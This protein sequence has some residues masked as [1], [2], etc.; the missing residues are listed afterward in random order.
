VTGTSINS[1]KPAALLLTI[2]A[3][4]LVFAFS[5]VF[6]VMALRQ[7]LG[8]AYLL[9]VPGFVTVKLLRLDKF[10]LGEKALFSVGLSIAVLILVGL[11]G[12]EIGPLIGVTDP[13]ATETMLIPI[14]IYVVVG[15]TL[16]Y[17]KSPKTAQSSVGN[18]FSLKS[19]LF[20]TLP[21]LSTIGG[22]WANITNSNLL[23]LILIP[24]IALVFALGILSERIVPLKYLGAIAICG[25]I[26][27]L[28]HSS[29]ISQYIYGT[30]I[31][32][33]YYVL[34]L[35]Q[36]R[37]YWDS[38]FHFSDPMFGRYSN[39]LSITILPTLFSNLLS[40]DGTWVFKIIFPLIF[41][42]VPLGLFKIWSR[43]FGKKA[44]LISA[45][46]LISQS[47]FYTEMLGLGRQMIAEL[48]FVLLLFVFFSGKLSSNNRRICFMIF[49]FGL[50]VAHYGMALIFFFFILGTWLFMSFSKKGTK[51]IALSFVLLFAVIMFSWY[52]YTSSSA[53]FISIQSYGEYVYARLGDFF[54]PSSRG[55]EVNRGLGFE[56]AE[57]FWQLPSRMFAYATQAL[58]AVGLLSLLFSRKT[59]EI[60]WEYFSISSMSMALLLMAILLPGLALTLN[61]TRFYHIALLSLS[62]FFVLGCEFLANNIGKMLRLQRRHAYAAILAVAILVPYLLFQTNFVYEV[63][64]SKSW[65]VPLSRYRM[66]KTLLY[67][68]AGYLDE[69][70]VY[71]GEWVSRVTDLSVSW[72]YSDTISRFKVL[73]SYGVIYEINIGILSNTTTLT[74]NATVFLSTLNVMYR[75]FSG[76]DDNWNIENMTQVFEGTNQIYSNGGCE[77]LRGSG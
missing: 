75:E 10:D 11:V 65:S 49:S 22:L 63:T 4:Q 35:T 24:V 61:M 57:T 19:L 14:S 26:A 52:V 42:F 51:R 13:L 77:V 62:P 55:I 34:G 71:G 2:L 73:T 18:G 7:I 21:A 68:W 16:Y 6:D 47:T 17:L 8:F 30:D 3:L 45:F 44:A 50:V 72:L 27:L 54:N 12:N 76:I 53:S 60:D 43:S 20:G 37:N 56:A 33:E 25:S 39:M 9:F 59:T 31:H 64:G 74:N 58:I 40:I 69:Q 66:E 15:A 38:T 5:V 70:S 1:T 36:E 67:G 46:L 48:F 23:L 32:A 41:S 28:L 29:L